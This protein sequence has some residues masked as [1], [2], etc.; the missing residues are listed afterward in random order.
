MGLGGVV[1]GPSTKP[2]GGAGLNMATTPWLALKSLL[3][4]VFDR[5]LSQRQRLVVPQ[6]EM[7]CPQHLPSHSPAS[8]PVMDSLIDHLLIEKPSA[9]GVLLGYGVT[10]AFIEPAR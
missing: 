6:Q 9:V 5:S 1:D 2:T 7:P 8:W 10:S 4:I 3:L